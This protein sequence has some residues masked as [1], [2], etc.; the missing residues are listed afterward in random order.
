[1]IGGEGIY[2]L[3]A[4]C[5]MKDE[6]VPQQGGIDRGNSEGDQGI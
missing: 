5:K 6:I 3:S 1:V 4:K 2:A